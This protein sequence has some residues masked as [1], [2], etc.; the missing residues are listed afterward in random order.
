MRVLSGICV[1]TILFSIQNAE[2]YSLENFDNSYS[3]RDASI[4]YIRQLL[5][6]IKSNHHDN[7]QWRK[8]T[9]ATSNKCKEIKSGSYYD[10]DTGPAIN[11]IATYRDCI[12]QC[13][14]DSK[15]YGWSY[16]NSSQTCW[17]Q[18]SVGQVYGGASYMSGSC[19]GPAAKATQCTEVIS[20]SYYL[21]DY[22]PK[23]SQVATYQDCMS[24]C[25]ALA[26]CLSWLYRASDNACWLQTT[27]SGKIT[28]GQYTTGSCIKQQALYG[29][30]AI[31]VTNPLVIPI[32]NP[33]V[34]PIINPSIGLE[35]DRQHMFILILNLCISGTDDTSKKCKEI[36]SGGYYSGDTGASIDN[37]AT[38]RD[39][40][41]LCETDSK[42]NGWSY[43]NSSQ[44]CWLQ[45]SL[46]IYYSDS[47]HMGGNCLGPAAKG[48]HCTEVINGAYYNGDDGP[49]INN[50]ATYQDCLSRCDASA[51]C[52]AWS[53]R[54][55]D[56][57]CWLQ[58]TAYGKVTDGQYTTGS[59]IKQQAPYPP[60]S[61]E[62]YRQQA[63]DR[64]NFY[65]AKHCTP[66]LVLD[67]ALNDI[68]QT[69]AEK[70]AAG[71]A[72]G[73]SH[74]N[75]NGTWM[76]ENLYGGLGVSGAY[77]KGEQSL[78]FCIFI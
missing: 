76:G 47:S 30:V 8:R 64:H 39:C 1:I 5:K 54:A 3:Q 35:T 67:P 41:N 18:T 10:G 6:R 72:S 24:R 22:G 20:G 37:I 29:Q 17:L 4:F 59:C 48:P 9:D 68:A 11:N 34:I 57:T 2:T 62:T 50:V 38:Y 71:L 26:T 75:F 12:N 40:M 43:Q 60:I 33:P 51:T 28:D 53:Y 19:L 58:T 32:I 63:L 31:S 23:I 42:C 70:L 55:S 69:Y 78:N 45:T 21:G 44:T 25:D 66:P 74:G 13:E 16:Q 49:A 27:V 14:T 73:H 52:L 77:Q 7:L 61:L 36:K 65:R 56:N 15:C 46:D